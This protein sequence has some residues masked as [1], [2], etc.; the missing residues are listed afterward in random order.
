MLLHLI[1]VLAE[2]LPMVLVGGRRLGLVVAVINAL[3]VCDLLLVVGKHR[4]LK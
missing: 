2:L 4:P 1:P 3:S